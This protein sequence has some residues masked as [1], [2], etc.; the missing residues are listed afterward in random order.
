MRLATLEGAARSFRQLAISSNHIKL[1]SLRGNELNK[2]P[3]KL[4]LH[5]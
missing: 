1:F 3:L 4:I 5:F 2:S